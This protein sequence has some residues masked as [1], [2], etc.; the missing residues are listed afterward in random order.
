MRAA[1]IHTALGTDNVANNNSYDLFKEMQLLGKL[2][3]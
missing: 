1:G 2:R 3:H